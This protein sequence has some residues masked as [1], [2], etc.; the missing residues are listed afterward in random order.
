VMVLPA[1]LRGKS[2][3][4]YVDPADQAKPRT[5]RYTVFV[6]EPVELAG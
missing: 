2:S 4:R 3:I 1:A 6:D 5:Q